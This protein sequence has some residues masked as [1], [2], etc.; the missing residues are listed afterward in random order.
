MPGL[1]RPD[2]L[3]MLLPR[4]A[5]PRS[6]QAACAVSGPDHRNARR[7]PAE[8]DLCPG[9]FAARALSRRVRDFRRVGR[10]DARPDL[11]ADRC[12]CYLRQS[13][14]LRRALE[15]VLRAFAD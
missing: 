8:S 3:A 10:I 5:L 15:G 7:P 12:R 9:Q 11:S 13:A 1:P 2:L 6:L 14:T 4:C